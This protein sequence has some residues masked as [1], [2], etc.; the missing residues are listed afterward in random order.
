MRP[1]RSPGPFATASPELVSRAGTVAEVSSH[2]DPVDEFDPTVEYV[3]GRG[4]E[5]PELVEVSYNHLS[6][7]GQV[8]NVGEFTRAAGGHRS[9]TLVGIVCALAIAGLLLTLL[10]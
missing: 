3:A 8:H 1:T 9:R 10:L 4:E 2:D 6:P 7:M 5:P